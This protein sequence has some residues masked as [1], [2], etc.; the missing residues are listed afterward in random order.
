MCWTF[1]S[2]SHSDH[3]GQSQ[4]SSSW[5]RRISSSVDLWEIQDKSG[6]ASRT[7]LKQV[8]VLGYPDVRICGCPDIRI[9]GFPETQKYAFPEIWIAVNQEAFPETRISGSQEIRI[10]ENPEIRASG[11]AEIRILR[12]SLLNCSDWRTKITAVKLL[13]PIT[14]QCH[15]QWSWNPGSLDF[16][17]SGSPET[18]RL[19]MCYLRGMNDIGSHVHCN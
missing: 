10:F 9:S 18:R 8:R 19:P 4:F 6:K 2:Q 16:R 12:S 3:L 11:N 5:F 13:S 7:E 14:K 1:C 17:I 15:R